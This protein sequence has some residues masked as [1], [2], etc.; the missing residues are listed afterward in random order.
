MDTHAVSFRMESSEGKE[1][2][3]THRMH[4]EQAATIRIIFAR[5]ATR[6]E[7]NDYEANQ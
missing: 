4:F 5:R 7:Q 1:N 3:H 6:R 2:L